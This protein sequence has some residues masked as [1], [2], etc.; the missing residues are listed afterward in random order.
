M[1]S[2][3]I[4]LI[5]ISINLSKRIETLMKSWLKTLVYLKLTKKENLQLLETRKI[6]SILIKIRLKITDKTRLNK[7]KLK[8]KN[9]ITLI[10]LL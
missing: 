2:I 5:K 1:V 10:Y 9:N 6:I 3:Q 7:N 4:F 8:N